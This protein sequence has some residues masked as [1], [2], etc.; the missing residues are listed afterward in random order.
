MIGVDLLDRD[1]LACAVGDILEHLHLQV[2]GEVAWYRTDI[3]PIDEPGVGALARAVRED[4]RAVT[5]QASARDGEAVRGT[6]SRAAIPCRASRKRVQ[7]VL[8]EV[9]EAAK[10]GKPEEP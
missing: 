10:E 9:K 7:E 8:V 4:G 2:D 3:R 6:S 5:L 1:G